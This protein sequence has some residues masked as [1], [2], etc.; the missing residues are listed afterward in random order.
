MIVFWGAIF[1][2]TL[3]CLVTF[4]VRPKLR[5][6]S[7][8]I[9]SA[10]GMIG[11][12]FFTGAIWINQVIDQRITEAEKKANEKAEAEL[13]ESSEQAA[14]EAGEAAE[15]AEKA[16]EEQEAKEAEEAE[17]QARAE[18]EAREAEERAREEQAAKLEAAGAYLIGKSYVIK[19]LLYDGEDAEQAM[20]E[21]RAPQ[22]LFHDGVRTLIFLDES[23]VRIELAGTY[24]PDYDTSYT[25]SEDSLLINQDTIPYSYA[26]NVITFGTWTTTT[27]GHV[28]TWT[29]LAN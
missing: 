6:K 13:K 24:R 17:E 8:I 2:I 11:S 19:P 26:D 16:K 25:L 3:V 10:T 29:M 7:L 1:L 20:I 18:Q 4:S 12:G 23:T 21:Y 27:E 9:I 28:T 15:K 14:K 22:S 5:K